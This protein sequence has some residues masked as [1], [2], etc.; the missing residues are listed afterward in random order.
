MNL[1]TIILPE[2]LVTAL[3]WTLVHSIWQGALCAMAFFIFM[4]ILRRSHS[5]LRY[6]IGILILVAL[7]LCSIGTFIYQ[8]NASDFQTILPEAAAVAQEIDTSTSSI[9]VFLFK[10]KNYF[11]QHLPLVVFVW[12]LGIMILFLRLAGGVLY[13]QRL[14]IRHTRALNAIWLK[15]LNVLSQRMKITRALVLLESFLVKIPVTIGYFKPVIL[16]PVGM[17]TGLP[18]DQVEA[19]IT[20]E[21]AHI[22]RRDYLLNI[23]QNV[24]DIIYFYHPGIRWI[25]SHIRTERENCCDDI[26]VDVGGNSVSYVKA[27]GNLQ[28][29]IIKEPELAMAA[30]GKP[31]RLLNRMKRLLGMKSESGDIRDRFIGA[32]IL[33]VCLLAFV[34]SMNASPVSKST[35]TERDT[36]FQQQAEKEKKAAQKEIEEKRKIQMVVE[37]RRRE[38]KYQKQ[39]ALFDA[40]KAKGK[41]LNR[42]DKIKIQEL[43]ILI[44][45]QQMKMKREQELEMIKQQIE[46]RKQ[47]EEMEQLA[48]EMKV[49]ENQKK[50]SK[51]E[52]AEMRKLKLIYEK[53]RVKLKEIEEKRKIQMVVEKRR[54][55]EEY[56]K[57]IALFE[58]LKAKGKKLNQEEKIKL[59]KL[60]ILIQE[61][62]VKLKRQQELEIVREQAELKKLKEELIILKKKGNNRTAKEKEQLKLIKELIEKRKAK[63]VEEK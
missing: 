1:L 27:S 55:E 41:K 31:K 7:L 45:E 49:L 51:K 58:T 48:M 3:G 44:Q 12:F 9:S 30:V 34:I 25:S 60:Q 23:V 63:I 18:Q 2:K 54:H 16:F 20:H 53:Q 22:L 43:Q 42:E 19:L 40:L 10:F 47:K 52:I 11:Y 24:I 59:Q 57:Q 4:M 15:R 46:V 28:A 13:S 50:L 35:I 21:L 5:Q 62:Q 29:K 36:V 17:I 32:S 8:Y 39:I 37:K 33:G 56:R 61:Q 38:E 26:V 6:Y 14:K